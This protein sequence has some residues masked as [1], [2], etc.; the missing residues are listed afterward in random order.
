MRAPSRVA[1]ECGK[2]SRN[3]TMGVASDVFCCL[4]ENG[5]KQWKMN[6]AERMEGGV[7]AGTEQGGEGGKE[8][9]EKAAAAAGVERFAFLP[10]SPFFPFCTLA[11]LPARRG[12]G[13]SPSQNGPGIAE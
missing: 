5:W 3:G 9:S 12:G 7:E 1:D 11:C 4:A 10:S 8:G 2:F 13:N 6:V